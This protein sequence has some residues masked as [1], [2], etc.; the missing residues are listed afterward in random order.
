MFSEYPNLRSKVHFIAM[1]GSVYRGYG[2]N[3]NPS[4]EYNIINDLNASMYVW[5]YTNITPFAEPMCIAPL[6]TTYFF[7]IYGNNYQT[8]LHSNSLE[9]FEELFFVCAWF[10]WVKC[11][12]FFYFVFSFL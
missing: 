2:G 7:Q 5:N 4:L 3:N 6:D 11:E 1:A 9:V 12:C 8:L 10:E